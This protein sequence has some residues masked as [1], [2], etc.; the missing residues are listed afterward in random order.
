MQMPLYAI[1]PATDGTIY[2]VFRDA[3]EMVYY[4][5]FF[6]EYDILRTYCY[7]AYENAWKQVDF[8]AINH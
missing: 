2:I 6:P 7:G 4:L 3:L 1:R 5:H 8:L